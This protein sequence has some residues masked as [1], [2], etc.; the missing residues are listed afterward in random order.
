MTLECRG[1]ILR[2]QLPR[3]IIL[4]TNGEPGRVT[5]SSDR[6]TDLGSVVELAAERSDVHERGI[7]AG[8]VAGEEGRARERGD[9]MRYA[10]HLRL[11]WRRRVPLVV[12]HGEPRCRGRGRRYG[13]RDVHIGGSNT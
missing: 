8:R 3:R 5:P 7:C 4:L 9:H 6:H 10:G 13:S 2:I 11:V 12:V 1:N